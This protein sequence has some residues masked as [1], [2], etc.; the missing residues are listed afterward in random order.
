[1]EA[2]ALPFPVVYLGNAAEGPSVN[3]DD[4]TA[5]PGGSEALLERK[6]AVDRD[7][8]P[9]GRADAYALK[10]IGNCLVGLNEASRLECRPFEAVP[11]MS[12]CVVSLRGADGPMGKVFLGYVES[13]EIREGEFESGILFAQTNPLVAYFAPISIVEALHRIEP[14]DGLSIQ[15]VDALEPFV[16]AGFVHR[17]CIP[18]NPGWRPWGTA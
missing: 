17:P 8:R 4:L 12:L 10:A 3:S 7:L 1:M 18:I 15:Y 13:A 11:P 6:A 2:G 16:D 14:L 5:Y 9:D